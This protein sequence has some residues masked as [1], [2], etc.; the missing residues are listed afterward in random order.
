MEDM[1]KTMK[2]I[3][4]GMALSVV[5]FF[6]GC[7]HLNEW[8]RDHQAPS[9]PQNIRAY[10]GDNLVDIYWDQNPEHDVA[11]YNVY[12]S[13]SYDG[14]YNLIGTTQNTHFVDNEASNGETYYYA[15]TAF[16]YDGNESELSTDVVYNTPR[17]EGYNQDIFDY[18]IS[19][20]NA[21]YCFKIYDN[22]AYDDSKADIFFENYNGKYYID[23]WA[24]DTDIQDMGP[25]YDIYDIPKAPTGGWIPVNSGENI[26]YAEAKVGHT[27]VIWT[28]DNHFAKI[29]VKNITSQRL[30]FDWVYQLQEG[31]RQLKRGNTSSIRN[32]MPNK[33][34]R[35]Y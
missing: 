17:P 20:N 6:T 19:P 8:D 2:L 31:N 21:G 3:F 30:V 13:Y 28:Q 24:A 16:D 23:V 29:R 33:V 14:K 35:K 22:V 9:E 18:T 1:M 25:T 10:A 4:S 32:E 27:Y 7:D 5:L 34:E 15:V 12:Y 11:G 26:K